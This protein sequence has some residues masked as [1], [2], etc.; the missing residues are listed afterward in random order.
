MNVR[1]IGTSSTSSIYI[2][3]LR[4]LN[5][6]LKQLHTDQ[7]EIIPIEHRECYLEN[8]RD[9]IEETG[10]SAVIVVLGMITR[11]LKVGEALR[12]AKHTSYVG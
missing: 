11:D 8:L 2:L 7:V 6:F 5:I 9:C 1:I 12:N 3:G 4:G 10:S